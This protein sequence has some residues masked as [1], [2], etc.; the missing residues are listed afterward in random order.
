MKKFFYTLFAILAF[1]AC[2]ESDVDNN[3]ARIDINSMGALNFDLDGGEKVFS[4]S[5][6]TAWTASIDSLSKS[7]CN[8]DKT[9]GPAGNAEIII[10]LLPNDDSNVRIATLTLSAGTVNVEVLIIQ[11]YDKN[12]ERKALIAF[13]K[14]L[15]GDNWKSIWGHTDIKNEN[16]CSNA[17]I[18]SWAGILTNEDGRVTKIWL[19]GCNLTGTIPPEIGD[20]TELEVLQLNNNNITGELPSELFSLRNLKD[21]NLQVNQIEGE[22]PNEMENLTNLEYLRLDDNNIEG[23]IPQC[24]TSLTKLKVVQFGGTNISGEIPSKIG[25]LIDL[26]TLIISETQIS[27]SIPESLRNLKKL[28]R[29]LLSFCNL[30][31]NIPT[32]IGN[33]TRLNELWLQGNSLTGPI[34]ESLKDITSLRDLCLFDNQ[35][36]GKIPAS[37][38]NWDFWKSWW[39]HSI[40]GNNFKFEDLTLPGPNAVVE[41]FDG[42]IIDLE[43]EYPQHKYTILFGWE[44]NGVFTSSILPQIK[45][46][47]QTYSEEDVKIIGWGDALVTTKEQALEYILQ[48]EMLWNNFYYDPNGYNPFKVDSYPTKYIESVTVVDSSGTIVFSDVFDRDI[49]KWNNYFTLLLENDFKGIDLGDIY[50]STDYSKDGEVKQLQKAT[51]GKGIDVVLMGDAY[52]D[53]LIADGTY[54]RTMNVAMEKFFEK[55]PY[56]SFRD[57]FNVYSV[58]VVSKHDTYIMGASTALEGFFGEGTEVGGNDGTV[59]KYGLKAIGEERM[60]DAL[61]VIMMNSPQYAGT[62]YSYY[63][64]NDSGDWGDGVATA[65]FPVGTDDEALAQVLHHEAGGHGF[66]KL[67]DEYQYEGTISAEEIEIAHHQET[68]G[69]WKNIDFTS[70]PTKVKWSHFLTDF[71]YANEGLGVYEGSFTYSIGAYRPTEN[72]IMRYN[73]GEFNAPSREA[74][75]YRIHKLA[76]GADWEYDYEEFVKWDE[77]NR[78]K[79]QTRGIPYRLDIPDNF[80]PTHPPVVINKSWRDAK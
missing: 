13:Y 39:G 69:W 73:V 32:Q 30:N 49:Y 51:K 59:F 46:I 60:D 11:N 63:P 2:S 62:C 79:E 12:K 41:C 74:I 8:I 75:Y 65:Y 67:G 9:S 24:L 20:L 37:F 36:S 34:P 35:L 42:Q 7:W 77:R 47:Y 71:R 56:K 78:N 17:P 80:E 10:T 31:G 3:E 55:E 68:F 43:K 76:Y 57:H 1:V 70:D 5:S 22:I 18:S 6:T 33:L 53:R 29:L 25:N 27:G 26:E 45:E 19:P 4:F 61:F 44:E 23:S 54:D 64:A 72:S 15:D 50:E 21:L 28:N 66:S 58:T 38:Y 48:E 14:A 52:S 16:W 40:D